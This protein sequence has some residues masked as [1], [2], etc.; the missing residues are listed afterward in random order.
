VSVIG[1]ILGIITF[2]GMI[3]GLIPFLGWFNWFNIPVAAVG[4]I[5]SIIGYSPHRNPAGLI[6][7]VLCCLAIVIGIVRLSLG[8][9]I[10]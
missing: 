4:L 9:G 1:L 5:V 8:G 10:F 7:I 3:I 6:G 2:I